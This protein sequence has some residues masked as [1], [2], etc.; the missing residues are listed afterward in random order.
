[1]AALDG[2]VA[3]AGGPGRAEMVGN[4]L[5]FDVARVLDL[6]LQENGGISES[7]EGFGARSVK[8]SGQLLRRT[9]FANPASARLRQSL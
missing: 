4:D 2:A 9:D 8:G 6:P 1:M 7:L 3:H 5:D